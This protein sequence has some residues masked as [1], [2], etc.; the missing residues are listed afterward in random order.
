MNFLLGRPIFRGYVK[1]QVGNENYTTPWP[2][3]SFP[4]F[5]F[6]DFAACLGP[7]LS[8]QWHPLQSPLQFMIFSQPSCGSGVISGL[9][10]SASDLTRTNQTSSKPFQILKLCDFWEVTHNWN[11]KSHSSEFEM[12]CYSLFFLSISGLKF[13]KNVFNSQPYM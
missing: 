3:P 6:A 4:P 9:A 2:F 5:P 13:N 1:L 8:N 12:V 10:A 11:E 7:E